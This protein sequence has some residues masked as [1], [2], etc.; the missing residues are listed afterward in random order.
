MNPTSFHEIANRCGAKL[1]RGNGEVSVRGVCQDTRRLEPGDLYVALCGENQDGHQFLT[2]AAHRGASG[3]MVTKG[4]AFDAPSDFAIL[5]VED[6]LSGLQRLAASWRDGLAAK[7]ICLTG[8][9]G[10]TSTKELLAA[11]LEQAGS[12]SAT[13]GNFNNH[14]GLPLSILRAN[15]EDLFAVWEIGMNHP[16]EIAPLAE[17][18]RPDLGIITNIGSAHI[19][20]FADRK[21]IALEKAALFSALSPTGPAIYPEAD[22]YADLLGR[23]AGVRA[24]PVGFQSG[25]PH[26]EN[27]EPTH[28]GIS[29]T[30]VAKGERHPVTLGFPGEHMIQNALLAAATGLEVGVSP[31]KIAAGLAS[32]RPAP[33][34]LEKKEIRG[35]LVLDDTYNANPDSMLAALQTLGTWPLANS[36]KRIAVLGRMGELGL[37]A[38]EGYRKVGTAAAKVVD[39]LLAV[40]PETKSMAEAARAAGLEE[41][42]APEDKAAAATLLRSISRR[43]DL[44]LLKGSRATQME[45]ILKLLN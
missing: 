4:I 33:G 22:D 32:V 15:R 25:D 39:F 2:D 31:D 8:S 40:G 7:V 45:E 36:A 27:I 1:I 44:V 35:L 21:G 5:E 18:A 26:A 9:S 28:D 24:R 11:V 12:V 34:R 19:E 14:I 29:F 16:G 38:D 20:F 42:F 43:G 41:V 17:L 6:S 37:H 23:V 13:R 3:A 10:K 30:L